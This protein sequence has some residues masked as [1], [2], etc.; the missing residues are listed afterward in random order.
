MECSRKGGG[1]MKAKVVIV[2][3]NPITVR[4][5]EKTIDWEGK[6][7]V[8]AGTATDGEA[9]KALCLSVH[10]DILLLDIRMPQKDG[11]MML[12]EIRETLPECKVIIITG[13]DQFQ[14]ASRAIKLSVFDYILKPIRNAEVEEVLDRALAQM[15]SRKEQDIAVRRAAQLT[16]RT[17]LLSLMMNDSRSGQDVH[18]LLRDANAFSDSYAVMCVNSATDQ[19]VPYERLSDVD[20]ALE[21]ARMRTVTLF[22]YD[23]LVVYVMFDGECAEW[24]EDV[25]SIDRLIR[26]CIPEKVHIGVSAKMTSKH[27]IRR[28][29]HQARQT[30]WEQTLSGGGEAPVF[31]SEEGALTSGGIVQMHEKIEQL[32]QAADLEEESIREAAATLF[33]L[34]GRQY[35][36]L[37]AMV[38]LYAM[39]LYKKF[40][41]DMTPEIDREI[42]TT[43]FA[44]SE[45]EVYRCLSSLCRTLKQ[46]QTE[47]EEENYSLMTR[48]VL[49]YIR[50]HAAQSL[51]L[52]D[53]ADRFHINTNY[54][55]LLIKR[56][57][58]V[59]FHDHV[60]RAKMDI[61]HT[62]LA[63][64]RV[65]VSEVA[66]AVG[67][68][69]YISFYNTFKRLEN[70]TP[71]E[72]RNR[73]V[74]NPIED[75]E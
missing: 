12:E 38:S 69:N 53:I 60:L 9:G 49:E 20:A 30:L 1:R 40:P 24:M 37:R 16:A 74:P 41:C 32:A 36:N 6:G 65:R 2:D 72:Y 29:Y 14:Y 21:G 18:Q 66:R 8:I 23:M 11:L 35:S 45:E 28:A 73:V 15:K 22:L 58:G 10:P 51:R 42:S 54:L 5:L 75:E 62:M 27:A 56:E 34:C 7:C 19:P 26:G 64:P 13:Y 61:A 70:M 44:S 17:H 43:L 4:S 39:M 55:S 3:D 25:R 63:D 71:T 46:A 67:Y 48:S 68:S 47:K 33:S 52:T 31:Y 50:L 59:T 57:T